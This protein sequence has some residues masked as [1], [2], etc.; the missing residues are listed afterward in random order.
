[1]SD[2][3]IAAS[4][5]LTKAAPRKLFGTID[6]NA[7][8]LVLL[9]FLIPFLSWYQVIGQMITHQGLLIN[10]KDFAY[11]VQL[12]I[13]IVIFILAVVS[14]RLPTSIVISL[15]AITGYIIIG[16]PYYWDPTGW[17]AGTYPPT[18]D[19]LLSDISKLLL[20]LLIPGVLEVSFLSSG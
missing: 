11:S 7:F 3:N 9:A 5:V 6:R 20:N 10:V 15:A 4:N 1:M 14:G 17:S 18:P 8:I 2:K 16:I 19:V 12:V 13:P